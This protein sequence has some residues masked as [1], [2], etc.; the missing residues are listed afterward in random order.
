MPT[1]YK[2]T[3]KNNYCIIF[4]LVVAGPFLPVFSLKIARNAAIAQILT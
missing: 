1:L 3:G 2:H 4:H